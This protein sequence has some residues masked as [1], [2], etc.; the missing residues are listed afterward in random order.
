MAQEISR[1]DV[2]KGG[3]AIAA[4]AA[5]PALAQAEEVIP[6][7]DVPAT[8]NPNPPT[9]TRALDTRIIQRSSFIT[10]A[11]D[12]FAVQH[13]GPTGSF[14]TCS[15]LSSHPFGVRGWQE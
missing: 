4:A 10:P 11:D 7:T 3:L 8:F 6:W 15:G 2:M 12:F 14:I 5:L 9:G 13:Y 1:R